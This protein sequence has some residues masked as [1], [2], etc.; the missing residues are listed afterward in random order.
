MSGDHGPLFF[1]DLPSMDLV[2]LDV[3]NV[4]DG[5]FGLRQPL[6]LSAP[7]TVYDA[8]TSCSLAEGAHFEDRFRGR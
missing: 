5:V 8:C 7:D 2:V 1:G 4:T 6:M 3:D